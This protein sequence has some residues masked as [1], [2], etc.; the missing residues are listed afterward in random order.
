MSAIA[1]TATAIE[2]P[3]RPG[4]SKS[5]PVAAATLVPAGALAAID[6]SGTAKHAS[7]PAPLRVVGVSQETVDNS[8]GSAADKSVTVKRGVF[9]F[10]NSADQPVAK[11]DV[12]KLCFV[13]SNQA[14]GMSSTNFLVAGRVLDVDDDGVWVDTA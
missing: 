14:V 3:E 7:D 13:E 4:V 12:G 1:A 2:T 11:D 9:R 8:G 10:Q 5:Y 6:A